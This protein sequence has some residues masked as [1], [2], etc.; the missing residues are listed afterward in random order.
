MPVVKVQHGKDT[1]ANVEDVRFKTEETLTDLAVSSQ[2]PCNMRH[3]APGP[4]NQGASLKLDGHRIHH[5][6]GNTLKCLE[7][8]TTHTNT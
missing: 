2:R 5:M 6:L 1:D 7:T 3:E 4:K 8:K